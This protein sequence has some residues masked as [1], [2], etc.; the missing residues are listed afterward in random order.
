[1]EGEKKPETA[2]D[3]MKQSTLWDDHERTFLEDATLNF[4]DNDEVASNVKG[5]RVMKWD[6]IKKKYTLQMVD[7]E[8][9]VMNNMRN[10][11]GKQIKKTDKHVDVYKRW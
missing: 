2:A 6:R 9:K 11:S 5:K 8:G 7:R 4:F 1:M 10:E 3:H